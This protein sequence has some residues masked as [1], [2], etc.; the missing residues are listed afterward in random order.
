MI[1]DQD[2]LHNMA[3]CMW[4]E[5]RGDGQPGMDATGNIIRNRAGFPGFA[6]NIHDVIFGKNQF[7]SM[8]VSSDPEFNLQPKSGDVDFAYCLASAASI[9]EGHGSD[10]T[11]GAHYYDN[12]ATATSSWFQMAIVDRP[13]EH[14]FLI[15]I[16]RQRFYR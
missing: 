14:P 5:S 12:P 1:Y 8:S 11:L 4:K 15:Q 3:L 6:K 9:L 13:V 7:S 2:D 16:G 10:N